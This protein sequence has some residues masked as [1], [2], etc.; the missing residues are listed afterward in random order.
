VLG[1]VITAMVTRSPRTARWTSTGFATC[2]LPRRQRLRRPCR[3]RHDRRVADT[4]DQEKLLLFA[5]AV[6]TV[7]DRATVIAGT[8][9]YDTAHSVQLTKEATDLEVGGSSW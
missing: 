7:G 9:T 3:L 1:S 8:G 5:A 2:E 4:H 6:E